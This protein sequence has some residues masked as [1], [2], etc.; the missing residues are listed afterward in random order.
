MKV[1]V[2]QDGTVYHKGEEQPNLKGTLPVTVIEPKEPKKKISKDEKQAA[3]HKL[4]LEIK[5]L[6]AVLYSETR[7]GKRADATR[8]L[9]KANKELKKLV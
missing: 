5:E 6:K 3:I 9:S 2:A 7:K 4:G 8:K 1:F